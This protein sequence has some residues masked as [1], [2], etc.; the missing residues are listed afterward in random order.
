MTMVITAMYVPPRRSFRLAKPDLV[1]LATA[2]ALDRIAF[3]A[4]VAAVPKSAILKFYRCGDGLCLMIDKK[5]DATHFIK[6]LNLSVGTQNK[7]CEV[8]RILNR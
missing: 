1:S 8:D 2:A 6:Y 3:V 5:V 4:A 7:P